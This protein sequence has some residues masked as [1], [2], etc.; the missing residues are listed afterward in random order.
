[1]VKTYSSDCEVTGSHLDSS[2][3]SPNYCI[4]NTKNSKEKIN[5]SI[6]ALKNFAV[7]P[8]QGKPSQ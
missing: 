1:M 3:N 6:G 2:S 4:K 5:D 7:Q 8:S